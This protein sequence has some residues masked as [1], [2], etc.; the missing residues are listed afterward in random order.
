MFRNSPTHENY[1]MLKNGKNRLSK[2]TKQAK[3][4][5]YKIKYETNLGK[6]KTPKEEE[7]KKK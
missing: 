5:Y 6:W 7:S 3:Q 2:E 4:K 1:R